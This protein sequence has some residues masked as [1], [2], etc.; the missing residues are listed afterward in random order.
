MK[1]Y[2]HKG[3]VMEIYPD[4]SFRVFPPPAFTVAVSAA[5]VTG[6][7]NHAALVA[8]CQHWRKTFLDL[9][10]QHCGPK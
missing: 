7:I 4:G 9:L 1:R 5:F 8:I 3:I 2:E 6:E 10:R